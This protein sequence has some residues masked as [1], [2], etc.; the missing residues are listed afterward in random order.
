[1]TITVF[2]PILI[3]IVR[4][5]F[6]QLARIIVEGDIYDQH[7]YELHAVQAYD[8]SNVKT[9]VEGRGTS[10]L[11]VDLSDDLINDADRSA[12]SYIDR[13]NIKFSCTRSRYSSWKTCNQFW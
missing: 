10:M 6:F 7:F 2:H 3:R 12:Q 11:S 13:A 5:N 9:G 4:R 8:Y 1:M